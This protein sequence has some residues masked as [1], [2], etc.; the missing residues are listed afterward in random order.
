MKILTGRMIQEADRVTAV[1]RGITGLELM[2]E[3]SEALA[4]AAGHIVAPEQTEKQ[5]LLF[6]IGGGNNGGDG[7]AMAR[8]LHGRGYRCRVLLVPEP[9]SLSPDAGSNLRRLP[10]DIEVSSVEDAIRDNG[11]IA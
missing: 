3:A 2:E 7:L 6:V 4:E 5:P 11:R 10:A 1:A 8:I 9:G